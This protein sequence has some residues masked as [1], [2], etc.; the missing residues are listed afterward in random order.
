M[1]KRELEQI[2]LLHKELKMWQNRLSELEADIAL[3]PKEMDG[4]PY[5]RTN[6]GWKME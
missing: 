3:S 1:T 5:S 4:M 2:Y 6:G